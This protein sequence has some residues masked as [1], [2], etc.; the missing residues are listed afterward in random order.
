M[1]GGRCDGRSPG[2]LGIEVGG[3]T[4]VELVFR[5]KT[6]GRNCEVKTH[7]SFDLLRD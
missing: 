1:S 7:G 3:G 5:L 6:S 2:I 4:V